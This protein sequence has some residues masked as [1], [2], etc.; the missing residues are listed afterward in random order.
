MVQF[1]KRKNNTPSS[2]KIVVTLLQPIPRFKLL[3]MVVSLVAKILKKN[4]S[5]T[6]EYRAVTL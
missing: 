3:H 4:W 2:V 1:M 6:F 5:L